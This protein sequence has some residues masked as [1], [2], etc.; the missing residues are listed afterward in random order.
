MRNADEGSSTYRL[1]L[2]LSERIERLEAKLA[3]KLS[4][5]VFLE[6]W[7]ALRELRELRTEIEG[8]VRTR[9]GAE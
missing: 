1:L 8:V 2:L 4:A 6:T 7:G 5:N 9:G 3:R